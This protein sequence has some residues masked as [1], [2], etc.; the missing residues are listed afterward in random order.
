MRHH[1]P[2]R[3]IASA[4]SA[5]STVWP[6]RYAVHSDDDDE[7][8]TFALS[9]NGI[10]DDCSVVG[11]R[12]FGYHRGELTGRHISVLLP[13][14]G[15]MDLRQGEHVNPRLA[16]LCHCGIPFEARRRDGERFACE[17]FLSAPGNAEWQTLRAILRPVDKSLAC[18]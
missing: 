11:E 5:T 8:A 18:L 10:I 13:K 12:L 9:E 1:A 2:Q 17:L 7:P 3:H 4:G 15:R 6:L 14:L 16:Y